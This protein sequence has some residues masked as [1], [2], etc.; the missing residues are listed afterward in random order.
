[1]KFMASPF[2]GM[3]PYVEPHWR[4]IHAALIAEIRRF[5]NRS[6]P[7]GL[8]ARAEERVAV[9]SDDD[10]ARR[11][12]PDVRVFSP[13]TADPEEGKGGVVIEAPYKLVVE[14]DPIIE[15]YIRILDE[16]G[17]L[18]TV[19]ELLSP[20]NKRSPGLEEYRRKRDELLR[21]G[22]HVVEID[23]LR[24]GD[25]RALMQPQRCPAEAVSP[26]RAVIRTGGVKR[27]GY[28]FPI[29]LR[30]R[31]PEIPIPLRSGDTPIQLP[32]QLLFS[33]VYEDGRYGQTINYREPPATPL[34]NEESAWVEQLLKHP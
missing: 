34:C 22:I 29:S 19:I 15:R 3:D 17:T 4:D 5:L 20:T 30:E 23:L 25:W 24:E 7:T 2:P 1:M 31:M 8:I 26:Y 21:A 28:L 6:L 10:Y 9:E 12:G 16:S 11:I 18:I 14:A 13:S 33:T 32:L 27:G